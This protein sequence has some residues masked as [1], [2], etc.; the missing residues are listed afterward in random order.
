[1][2]QAVY[3]CI[4]ECMCSRQKSDLTFSDLRGERDAHLP[5]N[6]NTLIETNMHISDEKTLLCACLC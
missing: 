1:M 5:S 2:Q 3:L 4:S 6:M